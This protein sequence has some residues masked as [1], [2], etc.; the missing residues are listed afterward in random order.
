MFYSNRRPEREGWPQV[1]WGTEPC[2]SREFHGGM[3]VEQSM[4]R[5]IENLPQQPRGRDGSWA[6]VAWEGKQMGLL[7]VGRGGQITL[8]MGV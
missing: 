1:L 2:V 5:D 8:G 4:F 3:Y 7:H 6:R